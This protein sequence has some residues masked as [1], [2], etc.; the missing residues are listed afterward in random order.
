MDARGNY[1]VLIRFLKEADRQGKLL[2]AAALL[3]IINEKDRRDVS[4]EV[5][6]DHFMYTE[7]DSN[8]SYVCALPGPV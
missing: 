5:L 4:Y 7:D 2:K 6:M 8:S 3:S 1:D